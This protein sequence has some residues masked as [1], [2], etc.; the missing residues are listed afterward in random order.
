MPV[1]DAN[2]EYSE[3]F[4]ISN[5][6]IK[7]RP[8]VKRFS[9]ELKAGVQNIFDVHYASMLAVNALPVGNSSP[10]YYYPGNPR[11]YFFSLL[12]RFE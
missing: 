6:E 5:A 11:N 4:G 12:I 3:A 1:N 7:F 9:F 10:R 2:S 8:H